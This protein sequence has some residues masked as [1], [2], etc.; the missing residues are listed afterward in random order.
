ML[1]SLLAATTVTLS[2]AACIKQD[3]APN[4]DRSLPT[5]DQMSI[6]LPKSN[7]ASRADSEAIGQLAP[8]YVITLGVTT[9]FNVGSAWVLTLIHAI[10][11][12]PPTSI[13]NN[14]Y[15]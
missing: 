15:T 2:L 3:E 13:K 8:Y 11:Q 14:V 10:V 1:K 5:A 7:A 4:I 12:T 6:K 9:T